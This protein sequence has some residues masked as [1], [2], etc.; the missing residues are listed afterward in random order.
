MGITEFLNGLPGTNFF[1]DLAFGF[2]G[3]WVY[4]VRLLLACLCGGAIG[5]ERT[6]R[7]KDAGFRTHIIVA[8]GS[9]LVMLVSKYGFYDLIQW[10]MG[11]GALDALKVDP[12]RVASNII[13]GI[14]FVGAGMIFVNGA[15]IK[16]L[17]TAAGIWVTAAVGMAIGSGQY[18]LGI[19]ATALV[20]LVQI[21]FHTFLIGF[22][23]VL[24]NDIGHD[25]VVRL[26]NNPEAILSFKKTLRDKGITIVNTEIHSEGDT[27][28][29]LLTVKADKHT[30]LEEIT[31][32]LSAEDSSVIS[33]VM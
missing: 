17:T 31:E 4:V 5:I 24:A 10:A 20:I 29:L 11:T 12:T 16:G 22:D 33:I 25:L 23:K 15:N 19:C 2:Q 28:V 3:Q 8:L 21:V 18:L 7:Q 9:A 14:S 26:K 1:E 30:N 13:S 6:L 27:F 32:T